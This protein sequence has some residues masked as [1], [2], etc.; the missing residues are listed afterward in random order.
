M[1]DDS[2]FD[3]SKIK[4]AID[5][6]ISLQLVTHS[7]PRKTQEY[8]STILEK[9]LQECGMGSYFNKLNY[10]LSEILF[11]AVKANMKR[12][13]FREKNLNID[14][15]KDYEEGMKTFRQ[16]TLENKEHY[17]ELL[18]TSD[19]YVTYTLKLEGSK[20]II[21]VRNNSV[22]TSIEAERVKEM[23]SAIHNFD[24]ASIIN[25]PIDET[26][27]AGLGI[28][29]IIMALNSFDLPGENYQI[30]TEAN[31]TVARLII[32]EPPLMEI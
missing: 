9:Y 32:E 12:V 27:G 14:D 26:E 16:D 3:E 15:P 29:S 7:L 18:R 10:C 28:K 19:L 23:I 8:M 2:L 21:E 6:K 11:N 4:S 25:G 22:M 24:P 13:Y 30:F 5:L 31:E 17:F 20:F 1:S